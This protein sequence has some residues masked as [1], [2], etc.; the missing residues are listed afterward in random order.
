MTR[1]WFLSA[2]A[3]GLLVSIAACESDNVHI[4]G[5]KGQEAFAKYVSLGTSVSMG[6]MNEG[7]YYATQQTA[8]PALLAHQAFATRFTS[9]LLQGP[10]CYSPLIAPLSLGPK[11]LSGAS[12]PGITAQD[13]VCAL[14]AN[15]VLPTNNVAVD[16]ATTYHALRITPESTVATPTTIDSDQRKRLYKAVLAGGRTQ[17]TSMMVQNPTLVSVELGSNE[18]LRSV[19]SGILIPATAYRQPDNTYTYYPTSLWQPQYD[20]IVDSVAKTGAKALLVSVPLIPNIV[21]V[22]PGD[23]FYKD[24]VAFASF[25]VNVSSDCNGNTNSIFAITKVLTALATPKPNTFSCTNNPTAFDFILTPTDTTFVNGLIRT[26]NSHIQQ[27]ASTHG[28]AYLELNTALADF[29]ARKTQF[30]LSKFLSCTRPFGQ[31][32]G[33]DGVHPTLDGQ[34]AIANAAADALNATY[35]FAIPKN[36]SLPVLTPAQLCP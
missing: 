8:W 26:M 31:Y 11:R 5:P 22:Y 36:E 2:G 24:S 14:I 13:Q 29:I 19:T 3:V 33:L 1:N 25:G 35:G 20:A 4:T 21:G 23:D 12:Y 27:Q 34:Q 10:G 6:Y 9:P 16:G 32:I 30:S 17:V 15:T 28:W 7:V 18:A